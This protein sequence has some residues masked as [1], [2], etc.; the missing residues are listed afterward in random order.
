MRVHPAVSAI[1]GRQIL[2][3]M[4]LG[5]WKIPE[6]S[7]IQLDLTSMLYDPRI[8][9]DPHVFRPERWSPENLTKEQRTVWMPFSYGP[10]ICI[11]MNF[12]LL[13]QKIFLSTILREYSKIEFA[14]GGEMVIDT[15]TLNSPSLEKLKIRC[16]KEEKA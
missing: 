9:G 8:W 2:K 15:N 1:G 14:P 16:T 7:V 11:G 10:R 13:E 6:G 4:I 12:S 3:E 5:D